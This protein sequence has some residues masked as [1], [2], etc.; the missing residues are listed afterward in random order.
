MAGIS[1]RAYARHRGVTHR[2]VQ[3]AIRAGR[4]TTNPDGTIDLSRADAEWTANTDPAGTAK[5]ELNDQDELSPGEPDLSTSDRDGTGV[6]P[7]R[8]PALASRPRKGSPE[9]PTTGG[10]L[11]SRAVREAYR[12]RREK[13]AYERE[14]GA[15][16]RVEEVRAASF[17]AGRRIR[18]HLLT[19][20]DRIAPVVA[21][22]SDGR[23]CHRVIAEE[24]NRLLT[25]IQTARPS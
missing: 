3:K 15:L 5:Y 2:A 21:G 23:E 6:P 19:L 20:A 8:R 16:V 14:S 4:I 11:A 25:E 17:T 9:P 10:F 24:V 22:L 13:L 7:P 18:E 12:A 1:Q